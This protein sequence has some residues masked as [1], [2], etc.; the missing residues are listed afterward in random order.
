MAQAFHP[1]TVLALK[2]GFIAC[3]FALLGAVFLARWRM[4]SP[5]A[6]GTVVEQ[7]IPFSHQHHVSDDGI[8]CRYCHTSVEKSRFAGLPSTD[9]CLSCHA[10]LYRD[11]PMLAL[12][13]RP[14]RRW[15]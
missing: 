12:S 6:G 13:L 14:R 11:A 5:S 15:F 8:D 9:I 4:S 1:A 10:Q 2:L 3:L 7:P